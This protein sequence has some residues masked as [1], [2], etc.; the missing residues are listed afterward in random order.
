MIAV[1]IGNSRIKLAVGDEYFA[2][3]YSGSWK[4]PVKKLIKNANPGNIVFSSVNYPIL[5]EFSKL[6]DGRAINVYSIK[7]VLAGI[8]LIDYSLVKG[9]GTDRILS[10]AGALNYAEAPLITIDCGTAVTVNF[11]EDDNVCRGG[12]IFAGA[13]TQ[14][15]ALKANTINLKNVDY[16]PSF[17]EYSNNTQWS[18]R[19]GITASIV[20]GVKEVI[21]N[22]RE[23]NNDYSEL[24]IFVTG[25]YGS[26]ILPYLNLENVSIEYHKDLVLK[27]IFRSFEEF[28]LKNYNDL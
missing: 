21:K 15:K 9:I 17:P 3:R 28:S 24:K 22:Y 5:K 19:S 27:G 14:L 1:D 26:S 11:L 13:Y 12:V 2:Y 20:G 23:K 10:M 25:G 7:D 6:F 18:V 8:D 16:Q 4:N